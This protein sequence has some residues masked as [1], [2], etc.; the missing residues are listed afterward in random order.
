[1]K[2]HPI[3]TLRAAAYNPRAIRKAKRCFAIDIEPAFVDVAVRRWERF[4]GKQ[5]VHA[6]T[7][8]PFPKGAE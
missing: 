6:T 5:A 3:R 8:K 2:H 4:T 1:M 7:G